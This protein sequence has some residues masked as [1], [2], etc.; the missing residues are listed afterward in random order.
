MIIK[1]NFLSDKFKTTLDKETINLL[2]KTLNEFLLK[3]DEILFNICQEAELT[4]HLITDEEIKT[5]NNERR[6]KNKATDVLSWK[7]YENELAENYLFGDILISD[8]YNIKQSKEKKISLKEELMFLITHGFLH[9][10][11]YTH[12]NDEDEKVMNMYTLAILKEI[13]IDYSKDII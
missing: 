7:M 2:E 4:I 12:E 5:V 1:L 8:D 13:G 11:G 9:L 6:Q 3:K 10:C